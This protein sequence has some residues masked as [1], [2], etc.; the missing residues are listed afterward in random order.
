MNG[1]YCV[2][3]AG[4]WGTTLAKVL[5]ENNQGKEILIWDINKQNLNDIKKFRE[6]KVYLPGVKLPEN[7]KPYED[8]SGMVSDSEIV[9]LVVPSHTMRETIKRIKGSLKFDKIKAII[10]AVKGLEKDSNK[11]MSEV[12]LD[13]LG[14]EYANKV[15]A[16]SGPSHAEEVSRKVPTAI[17]AA[18][19]DL[20]ALKF[21]QDI[22]SLPYFRVY[23]SLDII[24]V[25]LGGA[26]KNIIAIAA[27]ILDGLQLGDNP[28]AAL[29]TRGM[30]E[31]QRLGISLGANQ[32][33]F[34]GLSG[35]GDLIVTCFSK[36][37]RNR[38]VGE[39]IGKGKKLNDILKSMVQ[40]SEGVKTT[41]VVSQLANQLKIEM[42]IT[43]E[44]YEVLFND[45]DPKIAIE[46]LMTRK[47]KLE[48]E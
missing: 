17:V 33:T 47:L 19:K 22:F 4:S 12:I 34:S 37:S 23:T 16:L 45:K 32:E 44:V 27:G 10:T 46:A 28:K 15:A 40:I 36:H 1:A 2:I 8:L 29:V 39:S 7:L 5:S 42:P 43:K 30:K 31:I 21:V 3:G 35:I 11:R 6:N 25:E 20:E 9:L 24:G 18:G 38:F 48:V 13:E 14:M 26:I 41:A